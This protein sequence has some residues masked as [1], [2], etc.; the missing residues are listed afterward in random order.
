VI[1]STCRD[2]AV[3]G[4]DKFAVALMLSIAY[5]A[6]IGGL[7]TLIGT[8]PNAIFIGQLER[9]Y[10]LQIGFLD[11]MLLGV[12]VSICLLALC[13]FL[14]ARVFFRMPDAQVDSQEARG[15]L[16]RELAQMGPVTTEEAR[17]AWVFALVALAWIARG[18]LAQLT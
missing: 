6:S 8:P 5:A 16:E 3:Q 11:W 10:G 13:W 12:P 18:L 2:G 1:E 15:Y 17:V 9:L 7:A 14:L 4:T